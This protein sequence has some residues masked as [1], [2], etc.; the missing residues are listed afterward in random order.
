[1]WGVPGSLRTHYVL[2]TAYII[3]GLRLYVYM[4]VYTCCWMLAILGASMPNDD[5]ASIC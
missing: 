1:M 4:F 3:S 5:L 2:R